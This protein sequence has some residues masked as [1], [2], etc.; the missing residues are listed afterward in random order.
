MEMPKPTPGHLK[1]HALAG[2]F[3]GSETMP[4]GPWDAKGAR[5]EGSFENRIV[6]DGF[7]VFHEYEQKRDGKVTFTGHGVYGFDPKANEYTMFWVDSAGGQGSLFR[8]TFENGVFDLTN[9]GPEG[10][11]R[12]VSDHSVPGK[13]TFKMEMSQDGAKWMTVLEG[14]YRRVD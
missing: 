10:H 2:R 11:C 5:T 6:L 13:S 4:P 12:C 1:L 8:G 14:S 9:K 7:C 3:A